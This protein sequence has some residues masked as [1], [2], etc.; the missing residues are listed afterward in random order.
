MNIH[1]E[2][3]DIYNAL[4]NMRIVSKE[5]GSSLY[6]LSDSFSDV[7][8]LT[9]HVP[10]IYEKTNFFFIHHQLQY[11]ENNIDNIFTSL[12]SFIHNMINGDSTINF[13]LIHSGHLEGTHLEFLYDNRNEFNNF[14]IC[15]SFLGMARRDIDRFNK[16][17]DNRDRIKG[18]LHIHRGLISA[19]MIQSGTY[20][21]KIMCSSLQNLKAKIIDFDE[22]ELNKLAKTYNEK[23]S[24]IRDINNNL[25][26]GKDI[27]KY[28]NV[29]FMI[30]LSEWLGNMLENNL[31]E[32]PLDDLNNSL[33]I[34][35]STAF[36]NGILY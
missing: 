24:K 35:Y 7:D 8:I 6:G 10:T 23:V 31:F 4:N 27:N 2:D 22:V 14:S 32:N 28:L 1:F 18:I 9:I 30:V 15:R 16:R 19:E 33:R 25:V 34:L 5:I 3:K 26:I 20:D 21:F 13:E 36:E 12:P 29:D 11:K 17:I